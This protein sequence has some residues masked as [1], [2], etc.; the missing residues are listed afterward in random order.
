VFYVGAKERVDTDGQTLS[1]VDQVGKLHRL[2]E[3]QK[4]FLFAK[5]RSKVLLSKAQFYKTFTLV[6]YSCYRVSY[7]AEH[8]HMWI[9]VLGP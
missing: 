1:E 8:T 4:R 3:S 5:V 9:Q 7:F 2:M 6:A